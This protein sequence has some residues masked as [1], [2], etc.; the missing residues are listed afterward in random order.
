MLLYVVFFVFM[1]KLITC[2]NFCEVVIKVQGVLDL[3]DLVVMYS[4]L[5]SYA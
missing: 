5:L 3:L 1:P 4:K 2:A